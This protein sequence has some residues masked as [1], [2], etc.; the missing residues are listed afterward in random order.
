MNRSGTRHG[1][2]VRYS[3]KCKPI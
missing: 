3:P 2:F 1:Q